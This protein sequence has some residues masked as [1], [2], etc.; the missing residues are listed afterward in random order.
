MQHNF[1]QMFATSKSFF[2]YVL[3]TTSIPIKKAQMH[4]KRTHHH[5]HAAVPR[6]F[7]LAIA[8]LVASYAT[9]GKAQALAAS[10]AQP[11]ESKADASVATAMDKVIV[12]GTRK[13]GTR[14]RDS[15]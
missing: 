13:V 10:D 1:S 11:A 9:L 8:P 2:S 5:A 14:L 4:N 12:T 6:A 7:A 15:A 3:L